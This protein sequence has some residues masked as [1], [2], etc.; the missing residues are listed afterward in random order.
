MYIPDCVHKTC[1]HL[2]VLNVYIK[3]VN[4]Y[5]YTLSY[6]YTYTYRI[7]IYPLHT[8]LGLGQQ[9]TS[10]S[11]RPSHTSTTSA[12]TTATE[13]I[14]EHTPS[15]TLLRE[16]SYETKPNNTTD[17][18]HNIHTIDN[19]TTISSS[20]KIR[21]ELPYETNES[22]DDDLRS[23]HDYEVADGEED[24]GSDDGNDNTSTNNNTT[25][26]NT[27]INSSS[28]SSSCTKQLSVSPL[29]QKLAYNTNINKYTNNNATTTNS[30]ANNKG[31]VP[32][33]N[34]DPS[35]LILSSIPYK[36]IFKRPPLPTAVMKPTIG[37]NSDPPTSTPT[38]AVYDDKSS[39]V[40][41]SSPPLSLQGV[42]PAPVVVPGRR[43]HY[44]TNYSNSTNTS[45]NTATNNSSIQSPMTMCPPLFNPAKY[46]TSASS[47][48]PT[49][50]LTR[51]TN[52]HE[53][54][55]IDGLNISNSYST[56]NN[57][58]TNN[59][60]STSSNTTSIETLL[61]ESSISNLNTGPKIR[62]V[63]NFGHGRKIGHPHTTTNT[64]HNISTNINNI[65][66]TNSGNNSNNVYD[67]SSNINSGGGVI[68]IDGIGFNNKGSTSGG[69]V[70]GGGKLRIP[71]P[72]I[73]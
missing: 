18:I 6:I 67:Y 71:A 45:N 17:T 69:G 37:H 24:S 66:T 27:N 5:I 65:T 12:N 60:L 49:S 39:I 15:S 59:H 53:S 34:S 32:S 35:P 54:M 68:S 7:L 33:H 57:N 20:G 22:T 48:N 38:N 51:P 26:N 19:N 2:Y 42:R 23:N 41:P 8:P 44:T 50:K 56:N 1:V 62:P 30:I 58:N 29:R 43:S 40:K 36:Q 72:A 63:E 21:G 64:S 3:F 9:S 47:N 11:R 4:I 70:Y 46:N 61:P 13:L 55:S 28:N 25:S 10:S 52:E 31:L 14:I 73:R 16:N